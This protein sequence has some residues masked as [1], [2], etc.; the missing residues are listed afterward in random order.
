M[1][2]LETKYLRESA[3]KTIREHQEIRSLVQL[4]SGKGFNDIDPL[5]QL[6]HKIEA[7]I[8]FEER[9]LFPYIE[10][11]LTIEELDAKQSQHNKIEDCPALEI[12]SHYP[13]HH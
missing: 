13:A 5:L 9:E 6:A 1:K 7:H 8:R 4:I 10:T 2:L 3:S 11:M 12:Y